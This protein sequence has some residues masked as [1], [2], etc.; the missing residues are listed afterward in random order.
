MRNGPL[1]GLVL[2]LVLPAASCADP[3][4][5]GRTPLTGR[6]HGTVNLQ[7]AGREAGELFVRLTLLEHAAHDAH[8]IVA[9]AGP[10]A[11][12]GN[13]AP[14]ALEYPTARID[15]ERRYSLEVLVSR[16]EAGRRPVAALSADVLTA[17]N[18]GEVHLAY[19]AV[20]KPLESMPSVH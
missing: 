13:P 7:L 15:P 11:I 17:G 20:P 14:F 19:R 18:A 8:G 1:L 16:D 9:Q 4:P 12:A 3:G 10:I 5:G 6:I 2:A